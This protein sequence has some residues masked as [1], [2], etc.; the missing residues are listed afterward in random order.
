MFLVGEGVPMNGTTRT[1]TARM[2][3]AGTLYRLLMR[4][5]CVG[6]QAV[7]IGGGQCPML[8]WKW[9]GK[10][11]G[12]K[13]ECAREGYCKWRTGMSLSLEPFSTEAYTVASGLHEGE[14][15]GHS[16]MGGVVYSRIFHKVFEP[17]AS[18]VHK[19]FVEAVRKEL[20][21]Y[22][23]FLGELE[24]DLAAMESELHLERVTGG[25][26]SA[27]LAFSNA[28][29]RRVLVKVKPGLKLVY[30]L[31]S[32]ATSVGAQTG[33]Q[34][35]ETLYRLLYTGDPT[36][37]E[38]ARSVFVA[39][40][41][42]FLD[43]ATVWLEEG[44]CS[45]DEYDEFFVKKNERV[46]TDQ[47][48][49]EWENIYQGRLHRIPGFIRNGLGGISQL[50]DIL[51]V[52]KAAALIRHVNGPGC[53]HK[54]LSS[55]PVVNS[56]PSNNT[57][58]EITKSIFHRPLLDGKYF[59][60]SSRLATDQ[61]PPVVKEVP[62][63]TADRYRG[64]DQDYTTLF[65]CLKSC[66]LLSAGDFATTLIEKTTEIAVK[67]KVPDEVSQGELSYCLEQS[68]KTSNV[69]R[70]HD[71]EKLNRLEC[72]HLNA[73]LRFGSSVW[74]YVTIDYDIRDLPLSVL[75]PKTLMIQLRKIAA[76]IW[77][78]RRT[79]YQQH[80]SWVSVMKNGFLMKFPEVNGLLNEAQCSRAE[81]LKV[82]ARFE[83]F[84]FHEVMDPM[85]KE[86]TEILQ[87][88]P[89]PDINSIRKIFGAFIQ[90]F[91]SHSMIDAHVCDGSA[92]NI[93]GQETI[94]DTL[95]LC[96]ECAVILDT[97][98]MAA[99]ELVV[100]K[101]HSNAE[102]YMSLEE[103]DQQIEQDRHCFESEH[104]PLLEAWREQW[105]E[106]YERFQHLFC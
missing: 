56:H 17:V 5:L 97:L 46:T 43:F 44:D 88:D 19:A 41:K 90:K 82:L 22:V 39:S 87:D 16:V 25:L 10:V 72:Y 47:Y 3:L 98:H 61:P 101:I 29:L 73:D 57:D 96:N 86:L 40:S 51:E 58:Q 32:L 27:K 105:D 48:F 69:I 26:P 34:L 84:I 28:L 20:A 65:N 94:N 103:I 100:D 1:M 7:E 91:R 4:Q 59:D 30:V 76:F 53:F 31:T 54:N 62:L 95:D 13:G 64:R 78:L 106:C 50:Q 8:E 81:C 14:I 6:D 85:W 67:N 55:H 23:L 89:W 68:I 35:L 77:K 45:G 9:D 15:A 80:A 12:G 66:M 11:D 2:A 83:Y 33:G 36:W 104:L 60:R 99:Y 79:I 63:Y 24:R 37:D 52:G 42:P 92:T 93:I 70:R 49:A 71:R 75:L 74:D 18:V 21:P 38:L 102:G